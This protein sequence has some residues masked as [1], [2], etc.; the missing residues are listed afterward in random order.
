MRYL[1]EGNYAEAIIAFSAAIEIDPKQPE[2]YIGRGDAHSGVAQLATGNSTELPEQAVSSYESAVADYLTAIDLENTIAEVYLK[3]AEVY[4]KLG[5][6]DA[7]LDILLRGI[8]VT[9]DQSLQAYLDELS[10]EDGPT[11]LLIRQSGYEPDGTLV[12]T[13]VY[14]YNEQ[15]YILT[16]ETNKGRVYTWNYDGEPGH[17]WYIPDREDY[18]SE[19]EWL[20]AQEEKFMEPGRTRYWGYSTG[21]GYFVVTNPLIDKDLRAAVLANNNVLTAEAAN[22]G[23]G[24]YAVYTFDETGNPISIVTYDDTDT[25]TGTANIEWQLLEAT[26]E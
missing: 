8:E 20:A 22:I 17:C 10:K 23:G 14:T 1:T 9:G 4:V 13:Y 16:L 18:E 24:I 19:E 21:G 25:V 3:A 11:Y 5:N 7:A 6:L 15:G 26:V 12:D 2:A